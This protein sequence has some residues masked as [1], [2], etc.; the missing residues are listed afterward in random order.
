MREAR[1]IHDEKKA[2]FEKELHEKLEKEKR[3]K[4]E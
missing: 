2:K 4:Q 3:I 1:I